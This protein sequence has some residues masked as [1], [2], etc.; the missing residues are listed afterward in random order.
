MLGDIFGN[1]CIRNC[2]VW[3]R[4]SVVLKNKKQKENEPALDFHFV[5]SGNSSAEHTHSCAYT[6]THIH[7]YTCMENNNSKVLQF[8]VVMKVYEYNRGH[9]FVI[10][11]SMVIL[12]SLFFYDQ[13]RD[14]REKLF[15]LLF[16]W[17][18]WMHFELDKERGTILG[19]EM[20]ESI[21]PPETFKFLV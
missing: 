14:M 15:G 2:Q 20:E 12:Y 19:L 8:Y 6:H 18:M 16:L 7:G 1:G 10:S 4:S 3:A 21:S 9:F 13:H 5:Y 11:C 17:H